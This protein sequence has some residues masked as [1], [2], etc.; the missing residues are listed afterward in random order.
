MSFFLQVQ[1]I[2]VL[3]PVITH[4]IYDEQQVVQHYYPSNGLQL[5]SFPEWEVIWLRWGKI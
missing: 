5:M 1:A 2:S 4:K 3:S